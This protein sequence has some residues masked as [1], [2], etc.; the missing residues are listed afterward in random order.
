MNYLQRKRRKVLISFVPYET[1]NITPSEVVVVDCTHPKAPTLTHHKGHNNP[2]GLQASDTSTGIV[3][4]AISSRSLLGGEG[5]ALCRLNKVTTDHFD[6]DSFLSCWC[7]INRELAQAN[8]GVLRH[9]SR[10]GDF[11]EAFLSPELVTS[12]GSE[13]G[14][15]NVRDAF[16]ALKLCCWINTTEKRLFSAPYETKDCKEKMEYFLPIF[17][18]ILQDPESVWDMWQEEYKQ[19]VAGFDQ[20]HG[21]GC[22][23]S[24]YKNV[25]LAVLS[26]HE[27]LH[28]YSLFSHTAGCD[29]V[30]TMYD[31]NRYELECK[32]T[33][34]VQVHSRPVMPRLELTALATVLNNIEGGQTQGSFWVAPRLT[35]T[36]PVLRLESDGQQL[37]K[38][39]RYGHPTGRPF[40]ESVIP[41]E[42]MEA[43]VLS[44][45]EFGMQN[46]RPRRGGFSWDELH[47]VSQEVPWSTWVHVVLDQYE[48]GELLGSR[49]RRSME[50]RISDHAERLER[51]ADMPSMSDQSHILSDEQV[52]L[53]AG[54]SLPGHLAL[55]SWQLTYC[56]HRDGYS[57]HTLY[58][59]AS[60]KAHTL[61]IVQDTNGHVFGAYASEPWRIHT[62]FYGT[63]ETCVFQLHPRQLLW[64][65]SGFQE[66]GHQK[67]DYFQFSTHEGLGV[68]GSGHFA[69]WLDNDLFEG[70][71]NECKTF[72]SVCLASNAEFH[73]ASLELW[74]IH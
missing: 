25:G 12:F 27:P 51:S 57:L 62:R 31:R 6:I 55:G 11:R 1:A 49:R 35:D 45:L 67:D 68:G 14:L 48:R 41:P 16:T 17:G 37:H 43:V 32:Y 59:K 58:R 60:G 2:H 10:I 53:L 42:L 7:Y 56:T 52:K 5:Y 26:C 8:E 47:T 71:S 54:S 21:P 33:Q 40:V 46:L 50:R 30:L 22:R 20:L 74:H 4:N 3:L 15:T 64:R 44:F 38:A 29:Y 36:G 70:S 23:V 73:V 34:F 19:V 69:V 13:D 61:L 63:G 72:S 28:Y 24:I 66:G 39:Q 18:T 9:M 65:W